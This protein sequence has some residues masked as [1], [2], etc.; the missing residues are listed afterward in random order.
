M[1]NE[2]LKWVLPV[3]FLIFAIGAWLISKIENDVAAQV[4][5]AQLQQREGHYS[6]ALNLYEVIHE[7]YS[8]SQF[9]DD[10]LWEI[11]NIYYVNLY[12]IDRALLYFHRLVR[13]Y[14]E[15]VLAIDAYLKMAEIHEVELGDL[16]QTIALL[17]QALTYSTSFDIDRPIL[18]R[19][20]DLH[21]K[22]KELKKSLQKFEI[23]V[24]RIPDDHLAYR[25]RNRIGIICQIAGRHQESLTYFRVTAGQTNCSECRIEAHFGLIESHEFLEEPEKAINA[26]ESISDQDL[27]IEEKKKIIRR[28][29]NKL[30]YLQA[31]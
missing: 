3:P 25:A 14:P 13:E 21:L 19:M 17:T 23:V 18:F 7:N 16:P 10:A 4:A 20:G 5:R 29:R 6:Q 30:E 2:R 12:D 8:R 24:R 27:P 9:A 1:T 15:S 26:A 22:L 31:L 11:A 28:L